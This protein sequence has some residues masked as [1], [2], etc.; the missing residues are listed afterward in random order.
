[1]CACLMKEILGKINEIAQSN[2]DL[3]ETRATKIKC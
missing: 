2:F 3:V 1:M